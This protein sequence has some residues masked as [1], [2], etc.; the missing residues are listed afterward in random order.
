MEYW[1][2]SVGVRWTDVEKFEIVAAIGV[3]V[4]RLSRVAWHNDVSRGQL[5]SW[6]RIFKKRAQLRSSSGVAFLPVAVVSSLPQE[7]PTPGDPIST[8]IVELCLVQGRSLR[9]DSGIDGA[10]LTRLVRAVEG[11]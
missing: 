5:Y 11:A 10:S 3:N 7:A 1:A 4:E 2:G 9:F 6:G 8:S